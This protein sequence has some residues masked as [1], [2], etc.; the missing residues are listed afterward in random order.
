LLVKKNVNRCDR[1]YNLKDTKSHRAASIGYGKRS[2]TL[3]KRQES[4]PPNTYNL[5]S[6]FSSKPKGNA[7]T[8]G[9]AREYF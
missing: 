2:Q 1:F 9:I 4:P 6:D 5:N 7:F 3:N 8:F